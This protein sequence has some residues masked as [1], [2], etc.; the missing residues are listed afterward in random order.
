MGLERISQSVLAAAK[1]EADHLLKAAHLAAEE[2]VQD[3]REAAERDGERHYQNAVRTIEEEYA[4]KLIQCRGRSGKDLLTRKNTCLRA[5]FNHAKAAVLALPENTYMAVM[6]R[7]LERAAGADGGAL[8]V[9]NEER[10][11]FQR[12]LDEFNR[13]RSPEAQVRLDTAALQVRGGFWFV[14]GKYEVDQTLDTIL[15]DMER[16]LA[17]QIAAELFG[18]IDA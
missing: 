8:R 10:S 15:K 14:C 12:L 5:V 18:G 17:P 2:R 7:L 6:R 3:A 1:T 16:E 9:H 4:R 13:N 11:R